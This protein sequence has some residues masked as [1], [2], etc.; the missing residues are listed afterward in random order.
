MRF[1]KGLGILAAAIVIGA[2]AGLSM[3]GVIRTTGVVDAYKAANIGQTEGETAETKGGTMLEIPQYDK[4]EV[5]TAGAKVIRSSATDVS[6]IVEETMPSM[7][8]ITGVTEYE[9]YDMFGYFFGGGGGSQTF[10][11]ES[12]G[13]GIIIGE[14]DDEL[15]IATNNHVV[16]DTKDLVV[17]FADGT[18]APATIKG[19]DADKDVAVVSVKKEDIEKDTRESI[20]IVALGDSDEL[21]VGQGV[22]AIGN[23]LGQG[24]SVTTGVVSAL[25]RQLEA[26]GS[27]SE[28][29]IQTDAAINP[30]NSGG[31]LLDMDGKLIGINEAKYAETQVEGMGFAI[32]ITKVYDLIEDFSAREV[33]EEVDEDEQGY[34]GIRGQNIDAEVSGK[35]DMPQG[36]YVYQI[37]EGTPASE[38]A[39]KERDII[40]KLDGQGVKSMEELQEL[41][42]G[43][44]EGEEVELTIQRL[45]D[46]EYE[47]KIIKVKLASKKQLMDDEEEADTKD[48][49]K[50]KKA[51]KK[52][53]DED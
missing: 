26:D 49:S 11:A 40:T 13:S 42:K 5:A 46:D 31:A 50:D 34:I 45:V 9:S 30:G 21:K 24:L 19:R 39:L 48:K 33:R 22:I 2:V 17:T 23:A 7:V 47:E 29:L 37:V 43:Y 12:A 27:A 25:D 36:V 52:D 1:L 20:R 18:S 6:D 28:G 53:D 41:L 15:A 35:Y 14:D 10:E 38:S 16:A 4:T 32:P 51:K 8:A 3:Y 44:K